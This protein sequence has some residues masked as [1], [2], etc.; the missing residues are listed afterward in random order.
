MDIDTP[1]RPFGPSSSSGAGANALHFGTDT[2]FIFHSAPRSP[3]YEP[4][5]PAKWAAK[6]FKFGFGG[7]GSGQ[8]AAEDVEMRFGDSPA[9]QR[10]PTSAGPV[11][12]DQTADAT[13]GK[14]EAADPGHFEVGQSAEAEG[15][16]R[17]I[18]SGA[19]TRVRRKRQKEARRRRG[20]E[21]ES[22]EVS[23]GGTSDR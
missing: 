6:N 7:S 23:L 8:G 22:D 19:V 13:N 15:E 9:R 4:Y 14:S 2:P 10:D 3:A 20:S 11:N 21:S 17:K 5:D 12:D 18:A 1:S 16:S